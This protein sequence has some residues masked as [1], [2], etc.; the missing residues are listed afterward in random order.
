MHSAARTKELTKKKTTTIAWH[1][2][3]KCADGEFISR[4]KTSVTSRCIWAFSFLSCLSS[5]F[6]LSLSSLLFLNIPLIWWLL[7]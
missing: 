3:K 5:P 2:D 6:F 4:Y 1:L 7:F